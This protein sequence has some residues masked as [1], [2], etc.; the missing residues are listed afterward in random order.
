M[1]ETPISLRLLRIEGNRFTLPFREAIT[2]AAS[3]QVVCL[4]RVC[5]MDV[6]CRGWSGLYFRRD[7]LGVAQ[8]PRR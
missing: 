6:V 7:V 3:G 4:E 1:A 5:S 2:I 8:P